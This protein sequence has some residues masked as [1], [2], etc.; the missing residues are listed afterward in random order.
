MG[1]LALTCAAAAVLLLLAS[2][3]ATAQTSPK[4]IKMAWGYG[5][6]KIFL[7]VKSTAKIDIKQ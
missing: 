1:K 2:T 3:T 7:R 5:G 4:K 6:C